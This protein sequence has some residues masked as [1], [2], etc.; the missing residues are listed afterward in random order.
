MTKKSRQK[1]KYLEYEKTFY[2]EIKCIFDHF[3]RA[4]IEANKAFFSF[5]LRLEFDFKQI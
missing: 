4:F 5:F 1:L 2:A 3:F